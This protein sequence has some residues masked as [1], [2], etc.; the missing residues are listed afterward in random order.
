MGQI[1]EVLITAQ[2]EP[3]PPHLSPHLRRRLVAHRWAEIDEVLAPSILRP[4]GAKRVSEEVEL[5]I[6]IRTPPI[7]IL[8]VNDFRLFR[9]QLQLATPQPRLNAALNGLRLLLTLAVRDEV[10]RPG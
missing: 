10:S 4:S 3:P 7:V 9:M 6:G 1:V 8:A 2:V 5:L